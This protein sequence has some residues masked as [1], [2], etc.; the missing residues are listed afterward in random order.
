MQPRFNEPL[1]NEVL[2]ITKDTLQPGESYNKTFEKEPRCRRCNETLVITNTFQKPK[3]ILY[4]DI[5]NKYYH[6]A[7]D[8]CETDQQE[9]E[10][11]NSVTIE[12]LHSQQLILNADTDAIDTSIDPLYPLCLL[13]V[14]LSLNQPLNF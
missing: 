4:P 9:S 5:T 14:L 6:V 10:Y 8:K 3:R 12:Q 2:G 13:L 11:F 7:T 1:Y